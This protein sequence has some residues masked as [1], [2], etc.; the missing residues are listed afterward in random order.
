MTCRQEAAYTDFSGLEEPL[1]V[2]QEDRGR[3][4]R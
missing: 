3:S 4:G 1:L 2:L